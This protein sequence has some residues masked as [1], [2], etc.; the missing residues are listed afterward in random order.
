MPLHIHRAERADVLAEALAGALATRQADP[1]AAEVVAVPAKGVERWLTQTLSAVLGAGRAA[2]GICA[3]I[4]FPSPAALVAEVLAAASGV[5]PADD[6]W[7]QERVVWSLLRVID[8]SLSEPWC[9]VLARHLGAQDASAREHR[10]GRRYATAAHLAALFDSYG[11]QRPELLTAWAAGLDGDGAG[12]QVPDDLRWQPMLWR[13]LRAEVGAPSPAERLDAACARLRAE[14]D[15]VT[16]PP[17][18]SLFGVT[19][20]PSDQLAVLSALAA[21]RE[22][23]L[24][25]SHPSPAMWSL[26]DRAPAVRRRADDRTTTA[27]AHPL[28]A[29]LARDVRELQQRLAEPAATGSD[30]YHPSKGATFSLRKS[31]RWKGIRRT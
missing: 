7:V 17:R 14:P 2:D 4:A 26:L 18:L 15:L 27:V 24:W 22:I 12:G 9:A 25:L 23:H 1:F 31:V 3:N 19:R 21:G 16:L 30:T 20:L 28:L 11:S 10:V 29:G 13:G 6:P 5:R 8:A